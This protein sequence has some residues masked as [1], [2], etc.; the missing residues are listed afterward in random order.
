MAAKKEKEKILES[1]FLSILWN[2]I[3]IYDKEITGLFEHDVPLRVLVNTI[4]KSFKSDA[5]GLRDQF[6][7]IELKAKPSD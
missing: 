6:G 7:V 5:Q 1:V 2:K 4:I 3:L